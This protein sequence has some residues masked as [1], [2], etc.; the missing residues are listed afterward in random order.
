MTNEQKLRKIKEWQDCPFTIDL[1]CPLEKNYIFLKGAVVDGD[2]IMHCP[3]CNY[4]AKPSKGFFR[5][6][7]FAQ[8]VS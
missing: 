3:S 6:D 5:D 1:V 7:M 8:A 2:V 4:T